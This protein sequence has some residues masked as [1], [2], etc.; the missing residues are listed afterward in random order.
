MSKLE[1]LK[2]GTKMKVEMLKSGATRSAKVVTHRKAGDLTPVDGTS[3][4]FLDG[5]L[6]GDR[7]FVR[8]EDIRGDLSDALQNHY[9]I[10]R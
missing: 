8:D 7:L 5:P 9:L 10:E 2:T 6:K 1:H 4:E 3:I